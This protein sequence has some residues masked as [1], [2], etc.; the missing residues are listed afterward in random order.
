MPLLLCDARID[1]PNTARRGLKRP[2]NFEPGFACA[3]AIA[4]VSKNSSY[5]NKCSTTLTNLSPSPLYARKDL[6]TTARLAS[7]LGS[8]TAG[9]V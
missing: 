5:D 8:M 9:V 6:L 4:Q 3:A 2:F 7:H 1:I